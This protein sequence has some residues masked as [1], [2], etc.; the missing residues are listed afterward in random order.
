MRKNFDHHV[1]RASSRGVFP[2]V[3]VLLTGLALGADEPG[4]PTSPPGDRPSAASELPLPL[5]LIS[6]GVARLRRFEVVEMVEAI[7]KGSQ[8]GPNAGWFHPGQSR[9]GWK[10]LAMTFDNDHDGHITRDE[11]SGPAEFF[12]RLDRDGD[13][14]ITAEDFDWSDRSA[15]LQRTAMAAR[16]FAR[17]DTNG[18]GRLTPKEWD[19]FFTQAARGKGYLTAEDL[20]QALFPPSPR[21]KPGETPPDAPTP[22][23]LL[24]GLFKGEVGSYR[25]GPCI[26]Q[27]APDFTLK[28]HD[29]QE[30][31]HLADYRGKKP[32]VL[33]FGSFT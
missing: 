28:T 21:P 16:Q 8:M 15:Y 17:M 12:D 30:Q 32:V 3:L 2:I 24:K 31:I 26:D 6:A 1:V 11:Y 5:C 22:L 4:R 33:V 23:V 7:L 29:G 27:P 25:E 20:R 10:W 18:N 14:A 19:A 13:T 9:Y